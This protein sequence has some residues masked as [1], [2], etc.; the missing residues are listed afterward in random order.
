[1]GDLGIDGRF[2]RN[3]VANEQGIS[4]QS[5]KDFT[6]ILTPVRI[7]TLKLCP[8]LVP[9]IELR[10]RACKAVSTTTIDQGSGQSPLFCMPCSHPSIRRNVELTTNSDGTQKFTLEQAMKA[11]K[12]IE[13]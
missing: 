9:L 7:P 1:L 2:L 11:Q 12:E 5:L 8:T 10:Y 13:I 4:Y 3:A 6:F